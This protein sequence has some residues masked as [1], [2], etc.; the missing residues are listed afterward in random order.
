M[1]GVLDA[2]TLRR[3]LKFIEKHRALTGELPMLSDFEREGI[4][5]DF[6]QLAERAGRIEKLYITLTDGSIRKGYKIKT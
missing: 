5:K 2:F 6:V 4:D 3:L 1:P